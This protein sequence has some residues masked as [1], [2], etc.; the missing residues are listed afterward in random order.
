MDVL[1]EILIKKPRKTKKKL[2]EDFK[3]ISP[4]SPL[5]QQIKEALKPEIELLSNQRP[6]II[7]VEEKPLKAK[8]RK[9][10][11]SSPKAPSPKE[12]PKKVTKRKA[13]SPKPKAAE[14]TKKAKPKI[15]LVI[16]EKEEMEI[17]PVKKQRKTKKM[18]PI[19]PHILEG[20]SEHDVMTTTPLKKRK[21]IETEKSLKTPE[22]KQ[23]VM[24][25]GPNK[26]YNQ[27]F[28]DI[29]D[30]LSTIMVKQG[31]PFRARAYQKAQETIM[32]YNGDITDPAQ[33]KGLPGIGDTIMEKFNEY[34]Q[35]GTLKVL[36]RE[37]NNPLN[38]LADVYG[39]GPKKAKELVD[40][41]ITTIDQLR[42]RQDEL[43]DV[44]KVGLQ[45]YEQIL[46]RIP[47]SEIVE[48]DTMFESV[49]AKVAAN[50]PSARFEIVGSYRRGAQSS[51]D[52][53]I[54]ITGNSGA[55]Y[56]A[57]IDELIKQKIILN[58]L[59]RGVS[60]TLVIA[61]LPGKSV[62]RRV[63]FL[64]SPPD[65]FPFAILYFTGSKAF[66]TVMR[67]RALAMGYTLNEHGLSI[68]ENKVKGA[69]I[70]QPFAD[71]KAIFDFLKMAY[72]TPVERVDGRAVVA[73]GDVGA[74]LAMPVKMAP[75]Q[76]KDIP[77]VPTTNVATALPKPNKVTPT[78]MK[79]Q[80]LTNVAPTFPRESAA[81]PTLPR[82]EE[83]PPEVKAN[84]EKFA[85]EGIKVLEPLNE[86]MLVD[87]I[88]FSNTLYYNSKP[89]ITDNQYDIIKEYTNKKFPSNAA[90][91]EIGADVERNKAQLPYEMAS[92]D[93]IKPDTNALKEWSQKYKG[94]YILSCKLDGV[95]G[96]YTTEGPVPKM[97]TRGNGSVGQDISYLIPHMKLPK[98][99]GVAIRGEFV[100]PKAVFDAKYKTKFA[101]PRNMVA[102]IINHKTLNETIKDIHF[103]AYETIMPT[104]LTPSKQMEFLGTV[105]VER[106]LYKMETILSN[107][108]LSEL[109]V[110]WRTNYTYEIDGV[111]V[112]NDAVYP[113]TAG[114][115]D[116]SF[117]FKMVL[118][119]QMAEAKVVDVIWS[120]SKDGLLKPRVQ[121]E[122]IQLG[123]VK[124]EYATGFN[125]AFIFN[126]KVGIGATIELIRSG[127]VIPHIKAVTTP[128]PEP[129]MP[130]VPYVWNSTHVDVML[131]NASE[132]ATVKEKNI[133]GFF[134]GLE[135]DGLGAGN[136]AKIIAAGYDTVGKILRMTE[137]DFLKVEGFQKKM[138]AK[139]YT[140]IQEKLAK[141]SLVT[142][143]SCSNVFGHGFSET[144]LGPIIETYPDILTSTESNEAKIQKLTEIKGMASKTASAFV[145][146]IPD[147]IAFL[148]E[149]GLE[150]ILQQPA[151][152]VEV[153]AAPTIVNHPF[154]GKTI[155]VTGLTE[156][157]IEDKVKAIGAKFGSS[158]TKNT[159]ILV[160]KSVDESSGK[161]DKARELNKTLAKPI[162]IISL[163]DFLKM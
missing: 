135:V 84:I 85:H 66:N 35:T 127:D 149:T 4:S 50:D 156:K 110:D 20:I 142:I 65:E 87:M 54:I 94:P 9:S 144:R 11:P 29:L 106:V 3:I 19:G 58:V 86:K 134:K 33:L 137:A 124:I 138:A 34:V 75:T 44:Q 120:P 57:F 91:T 39:I 48:Y 104:G 161:L 36:E 40:K 8:T 46:E 111:I 89:I 79:V 145:E 107:E 61:K 133:T 147:F 116:H 7:I 130:S 126:N 12:K 158:I 2:L 132:D 92:M 160:A 16:E 162:Q 129:K 115:P 76:M 67:N 121:I 53:D 143:M 13:E 17:I 118:S 119:D 10:K 153:V 22:V 64:Y 80:T 112:A 88:R 155:V 128:A 139:I 69:K 41:G 141:A 131:E 98:T 23:V 148:K 96:L 37:K 73:L 81:A 113:R 125:G 97:Y 31:E 150:G 56:K 123:G 27:E 95:S 6:K 74:T 157:V 25:Q 78:P 45:Y 28:I 136:V 32:S 90:V 83:I 105:D 70:E 51:G 38:I 14:K 71:E 24:N 68:M 55:I 114:N 63:D 146:K 101:N 82:A 26:V 47:R 151:A 72:K 5:K 52:I 59:S 163:D 122:P 60:K 77:S 152:K 43:N 30:K 49:F 99:K 140:G 21:E 100:I 108:M 109:L 18:L 62:A 102:G 103:V 159:D 1:S 42:A 117:A 15:E 154:N 93:K